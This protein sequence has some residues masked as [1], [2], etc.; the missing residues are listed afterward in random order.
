MSS[1]PGMRFIVSGF[2]EF[3]KPLEPSRDGE[4]N[5]DKTS[6]TLMVKKAAKDKEGRR[7]KKKK[8]R[9]QSQKKKQKTSL[10]KR[11]LV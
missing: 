2:D 11:K 3:A 10:K 7:R 5:A 8:S 4:S 6:A 1:D 9:K